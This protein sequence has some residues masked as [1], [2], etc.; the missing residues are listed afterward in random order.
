MPSKQISQFSS[1]E[2]GAILLDPHLGQIHFP[3]TYFMRPSLSAD[4]R[5]GLSIGGWNPDNCPSEAIGSRSVSRPASRASRPV[6]G[7]ASDMLSPF[8][9]A[10]SASP[11]T[12]ALGGVL[13]SVVCPHHFGFDDRKASTVAREH[14]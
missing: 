8:V 1:V 12:Q 5:G 10:R 6:R 7:R 4:I 2:I 9:I 13:A 11:D 3:N 14:V